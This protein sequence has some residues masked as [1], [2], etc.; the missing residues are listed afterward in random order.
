MKRI[1][2]VTGVLALLAMAAAVSGLP[3]RPAA[4]GEGP[5]P[6]LVPIEALTPAPTPPDRREVAILTLVIESDPE[7]QIVLVAMEQARILRSY[8]PNVVNRTGPWTVELLGETELRYGVQDP[9]WREVFPVDRDEPFQNEYA[10][11]VVWELVVPLYLFDRD[12]NVQAINLYDQMG[13][14]IFATEVDRE[15]WR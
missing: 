8:A 6:T 5:K 14:L 4:Q 9:R 10:A 12:L 11:S 13:N 7:G 15:N 2:L 3:L 1:L